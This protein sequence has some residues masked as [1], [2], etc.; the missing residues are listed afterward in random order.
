M[1]TSRRSIRSSCL[2]QR[3]THTHVG[4]E[5]LRFVVDQDDLLS[6]GGILVDSGHDVPS[7]GGKF[8]G[9]AAAALVRRVRPP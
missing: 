2:Y 4:T 7:D 1:T 6:L 9:C 8:T 5:L 3:H